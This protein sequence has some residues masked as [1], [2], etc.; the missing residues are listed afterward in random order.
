M[1]LI[2]LTRFARERISPE[3]YEFMKSFAAVFYSLHLMPLILVDTECEEINPMFGGL[4]S[5]LIIMQLILVITYFILIVV[6]GILFIYGC[7][8]RPND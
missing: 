6:W 8:A 7:K 4:F 2:K 1:L 5:S 3:R